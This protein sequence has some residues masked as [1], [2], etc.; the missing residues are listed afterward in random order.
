MKKSKSMDK[1][2]KIVKNSLRGMKK[3]IKTP[4]ILKENRKY[5]L[6]LIWKQF[7]NLYPNIE[8]KQ[9]HTRLMMSHLRQHFKGKE[10]QSII[11]CIKTKTDIQI[12]VDKIVQNQWDIKI[13]T[14]EKTIKLCIPLSAIKVNKGVKL[15][16]G[17]EEAA[18]MD[19]YCQKCNKIVGNTDTKYWI[20]MN[21]VHNMKNTIKKTIKLYYV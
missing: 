20:H 11:N 16:R 17:L 5:F 21:E 19:Y 14:I 15:G 4:L 9:T 2:L 12:A 7:L 3:L 6:S 18:T 1:T 10:T 13:K 8:N